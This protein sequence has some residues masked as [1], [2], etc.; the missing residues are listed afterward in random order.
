MAKR[1][2]RLTDTEREQR[3][4]QDR[5][6]LKQACEQL[7][8]S[9][10]WQRWV[11]ARARNGLARYSVS[12]LCLILLANPH[13]SFVAGF[14]AWLELGYCV[15]KGEHAIWIFAPM[16]L[17]SRP[18]AESCDDEPSDAARVLFRAVPVFDRSQV[19][20][21]DDREPAPLEPPSQPLT[22]D[23]HAALLEP[24]AAFA[25]SFGYDVAYE[26]TAS[27][28]GGWC[29][30][31]RRRIVIDTD[32][33]ANAQLRIAIHETAHALGIKASGTGLS[34]R[35]VRAAIRRDSVR[36]GFRE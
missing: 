9:V 35:A 18:D 17:R 28:V 11:R 34:R 5:E 14:K 25:A 27:G 4:A 21:R 2:R 36:D 13:A 15:R 1:T 31:Q 30:H 3:R 16:P 20:A 10:G 12:N 32:A 26:R 24:A 23:S 6:R 7:L 29:D 8:S 19:D 33:P 22:G